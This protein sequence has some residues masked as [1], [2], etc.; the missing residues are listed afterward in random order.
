MMKEVVGYFGRISHLQPKQYGVHVLTTWY[1]LAPGSSENSN[2]DFGGDCTI[3][4][5]IW[6][7]R[8]LESNNTATP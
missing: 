4:T 1:G 6:Q 2:N 7:H 3:N 5:Y 8:T